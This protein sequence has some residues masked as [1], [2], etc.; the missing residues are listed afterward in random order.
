MRTRI[1]ISA[2]LAAVF[3]H[4]SYGQDGLL[5][6]LEKQRKDTVFNTQATFKTIRISIGHSVETRKKGI[7]E[8]SAMTRYWNTF[9][10]T[11]NS[12]VADKMTARFGID[13]GISDRFST[14]IGM[15]TLDGILD[16]YLKY[17]LMQQ[18]D[19]GKNP[20][21]ITLLQAASLRTNRFNNLMLSDTFGDRL[22]F[23][24]Q[25]LIARK[26]NKNFS[27]QIA[28]TYIHRGSASFA[29]DDTNHFA[30]GFG[31]R[32]KIGNHVSVVSE[33][34]YLFNELESVK[35][36]D[37]FVVGVNWEIADVILQ[38]KLTNTRNFAE[39]TFITQTPVNFNFK[40]GYLSFGFQFNYI[41][42]LNQR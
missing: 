41:L 5:G 23:T 25:V 34:Y 9:A 36:F 11:S 42:H 19:S 10:P 35:T 26:I 8:L 31:G 6:E 30:I 21:S 40:P 13:Y 37:A 4:F 20:L 12:F 7:L 28:P 29:Q 32:Y 38:F 22:S 27:L 24:S 18:Q 17:R 2:V 3:S 16:A 39:D 33:Y 14:G 15:A 1:L